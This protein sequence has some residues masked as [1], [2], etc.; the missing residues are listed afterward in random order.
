[1]PK[2]CGPCETS[3]PASRGMQLFVQSRTQSTLPLVTCVDL[4]DK[5]Y[6]VIMQ[7]IWL[8]MEWGVKPASVLTTILRTCGRLIRVLA[9][10]AQAILAEIAEGP[11]IAELAW[12]TTAHWARAH[13]IYWTKPGRQPPLTN[14]RHTKHSLEVQRLHEGDTRIQGAHQGDQQNPFSLILPRRTPRMIFLTTLLALRAPIF[15]LITFKYTTTAAHSWSDEGGGPGRITRWPVGAC[16]AVPALPWANV[17]AAASFSVRMPC[18]TAQSRVS[19][20][21]L[22][23]THHSADLY[24]G[25]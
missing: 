16:T 5:V 20:A 4:P 10:L 15:S 25:G 9:Y 14:V 8:Y 11:R 23:S 21:T 2:G 13:V 18:L 24:S 7:I 22:H 6:L 19:L 1:M 3:L 12:G 17:M